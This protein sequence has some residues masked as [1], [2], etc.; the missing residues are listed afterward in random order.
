MT[1]GPA[2]ISLLDRIIEQSLEP[3]YRDAARLR[4]V[5]GAGDGSPTRSGPRRIPLLVVGWAVIGALFIVA[6]QQTQA[7]EPAE[8]ATRQALLE[9]LDVERAELDAVSQ[10]LAEARAESSRLGR[11]LTAQRRELQK[12]SDRAAT[13]GAVSGFAAV[14]GPGVVY[15]VDSAAQADATHRVQDRD[16]QLL[17]NGLAVAGAEAVAINDQ[18]LSSFSA[19]RNSGAGIRINRVTVNPPYTVAA[20]GDVRTLA[21]DFVDT[22]S[23]AKWQSL[24]DAL[25][26][27]V[28]QANRDSLELPAAPDFLLD[29]CTQ[30]NRVNKPS[31]DGP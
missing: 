29:Q 25:G 10:A 17:V 26:F 5:D 9:R 4:A 23:G 12:A 6:A 21:A 2:H 31:G 28:S 8:L 7:D 16:L 18:R 20:I 19:I 14:S 13:L 27:T 3:E 1:T 30:C 22:E 24:V 11:V 15:T